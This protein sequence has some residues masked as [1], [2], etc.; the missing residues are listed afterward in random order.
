M[1]AAQAHG[2]RYLATGAGFGSLLAIAGVY[3]AHVI[4]RALKVH[5]VRGSGILQRL[6][7]ASV[8][9]GLCIGGGLEYRFHQVRASAENRSPVS[10]PMRPI[11]ASGVVHINKL[12]HQV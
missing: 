7:F 4:L 10:S 9:L 2:F 6:Q 5:P 11:E 1:S 12:R 8:A 3:P